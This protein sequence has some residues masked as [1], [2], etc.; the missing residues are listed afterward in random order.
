MALDERRLEVLDGHLGQAQTADAGHLHVEQAACFESLAPSVPF[1]A[2][3]RKPKLRRGT[4][5]SDPMCGPHQGFEFRCCSSGRSLRLHQSGILQLPGSGELV[6]LHTSVRVREH[7]RAARKTSDLLLQLDNLTLVP[8]RS[9]RN[10]RRELVLRLLH[11]ASEPSWRTAKSAHR[12]RSHLVL[13]SLHFR[14]VIA[15]F[16][17]LCRGR[18]SGTPA[19]LHILGGGQ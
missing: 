19:R 6:D 18:G 1:A 5:A 15:R 17:K 4:T 8:G 10:E 13:L 7:G 14:E 2:P 9:L 16:G 12:P 11:N 3:P